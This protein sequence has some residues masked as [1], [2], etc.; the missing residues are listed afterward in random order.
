VNAPEHLW[1]LMGLLRKK[2]ELDPS[3]P[4]HLLSERWVG[5]PFALDPAE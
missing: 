3:R 4:R 2:V 1:V 5:Y